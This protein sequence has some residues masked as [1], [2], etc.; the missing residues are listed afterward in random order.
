MISSKIFSRLIFA[1]LLILYGVLFTQTI[2][3]VT[4]DLGRHLKNGEIFFSDFSI[5]K[6]NLYSYTY[7]DYPFINHHWGSGIIFYLVQ[8][9]VGFIGLSIFYT[10]ISLSAFWFFFQTARRLG[11]TGIAAALSMLALPLILTRSEIRPEGF[12]YLLTGFFFWLLWQWRDGRVHRK[13]LFL[14]PALI[15][16]WVNLHIYFFLGLALVGIF[17][18][19]EIW[20]WFWQ[21]ENRV[22]ILSQ[23]KF[24]ALIFGLCLF[25]ALL[26]PFGVKGVL[27]PLQI[28]QNYNYMV[29]ENQSVSFIENLFLY[30]AGVY[31][32][33]LIGALFLSWLVV[34]WKKSTFYP[35]HFLLSVGFAV[36]S[37][38]AIRNFSIFAYLAIPIAALNFRPFFKKE[39]QTINEQYTWFA[40]LIVLLV[41]LI[42]IQ[43]SFWEGMQ[44]KVGIG[45]SKNVWGAGEFIQKHQIRGPFFNDYDIGSYLVYYLYPRERV[46][47]ENRPEAYPAAFWDEYRSIQVNPELWRK[48]VQKYN[49]QAIL[50]YRGN[51]SDGTQDFLIR[52]I[53]DPLWA[54][55]YVDDF[56]ILFARRG[57]LNQSIIK[58]SEIP[59]S[60][61]EI[62]GSR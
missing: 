38:F 24:L 58:S 28:F 49:F 35:G 16:I 46:F 31:I 10:L 23:I 62:T 33:L 50:V 34:F 22:A 56:S 26:N 45:L 5:P 54:P 19:E 47:A 1:V 48:A 53:D 32:R 4:V 9:A 42:L 27:Y 29:V 44:R 6:T 21:K 43:P 36:L 12:S 7:P 25:A 13:W 52:M 60:W 17:L 8:K 11:N 55:V 3:F 30:P 37:W 20:F 14:L 51:L 57:G 59:R 18:F 40:S 41:T 2:S 61:F 39:S 15:A